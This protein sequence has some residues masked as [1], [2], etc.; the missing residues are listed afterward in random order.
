MTTTKMSNS[1]WDAIEVPN[2]AGKY[3]AQLASDD[4][5]P[6]RKRTYWAKAY[7]G[8]LAL[9][10][11]YTEDPWKP[12]ELPSFKNL[13]VEDHRKESCLTIE[14]CNSEMKDLFHKICLDLIDALQNAPASASRQ[15]CLLRLS[16]WSAVFKHARKELSPEAQK[17][18]M[19]ELRF[20]MRDALVTHDANDVLECWTGPDAGPRDF[21]FGQTFVEVKSK[22]SSANTTITISSEEQLNINPSEK[23]YL[24]VSE[25]NSAPPDDETSISIEDIVKE[26]R[27]KFNTPLQSALLESKLANAGYFSEVDYSATR[28][29]E[30]ETYYYAVIDGFPKIDSKSCDPGVSKVTYQIDLDYC[31]DFN[32]DRDDLLDSLR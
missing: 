8:N 26:A 6:G 27:E 4:I 23:L 19:A 10:I 17:G 25:F 14:L 16:K 5:N 30:G 21:E 11:E 29:T 20:L 22:R 9:L 3:I 1:P 12:L 32:I 24:C 15:V 18:L 13:R 2:A 31:F 7:S 28:W